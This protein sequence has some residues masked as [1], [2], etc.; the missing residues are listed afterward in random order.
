M[1]AGDLK[2]LIYLVNQGADIDSQ[3]VIWGIPLHVAASKGC[4]VKCLVQNEL[5]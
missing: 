2:I 4:M 5:T 1:A 3:D